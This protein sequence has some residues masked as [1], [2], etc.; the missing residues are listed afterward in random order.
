MA[1]FK[2]FAVCVVVFAVLINETDACPGLFGGGGGGCG[3]MMAPPPP[4]CGGGC[5]RKKR[6]VLEQQVKTFDS[7]P[8]PQASWKAVM[9]PNLG[10]DATSTAYAVQG[11]LTKAY[12]AKFFVTCVNVADK[13]K[14]ETVFVANGEGYC[15][16][17]NDKIWCEALA[18]LG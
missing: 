5:G 1:S 14:P 2:V 18:I 13:A 7:N 8:C 11:A 6:E 17:G 3:C 9:D 10:S 12:E 16:Y 15:S 4:P